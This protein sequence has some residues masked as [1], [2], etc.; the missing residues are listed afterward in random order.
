M[1]EHEKWLICLEQQRK[2]EL[3]KD[4]VEMERW[5]AAE[6]EAQEEYLALNDWENSQYGML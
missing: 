2:T 6:A 4:K 5:E 1:T 3:E